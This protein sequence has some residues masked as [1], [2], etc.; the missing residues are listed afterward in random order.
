ML[1][2]WKLAG[3]SRT[4]AVKTQEIYTSFKRVPWFKAPFAFTHIHTYDSA[5]YNLCSQIA[6]QMI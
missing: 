2:K 5:A 6:A 4:E 3:V 1:E